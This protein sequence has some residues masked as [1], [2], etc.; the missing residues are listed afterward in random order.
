MQISEPEESVWTIVREAAVPQLPAQTL[1][2]QVE[3]REG[4]PIAAGPL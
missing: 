3:G 1:E 2:F 4:D